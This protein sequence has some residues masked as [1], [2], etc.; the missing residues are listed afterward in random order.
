MAGTEPIAMKL[1]LLAVLANGIIPADE[2]D[3]GAVSV[4]ADKRL[5]ARI[6]AGVNAQLY[7]AGIDRAE[8]VSQ[9]RFGSPLTSLNPHQ[10]HELIGM[11]RTELPGF[12]KQLRMD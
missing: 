3:T 4:E 8:A 6:D 11:L 5:V 7:R 1:P 10:V 2:R 12:Y 9:E